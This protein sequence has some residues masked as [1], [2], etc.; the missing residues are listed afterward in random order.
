MRIL[1]AAAE[2]APYIKTGGLGDVIFALPA[3]LSKKSDT[4]V[5]VFLPYYKAIKDNREIETEFITSFYTTLNWRKAHIGI[6]KAK[7]NSQKLK[8]YF[9]DNEYYFGRDNLYGYYDD[10]ERFAYFS[11]ALL[12]A[13]YHIDFVP[14]VIHA[15]DWH[16]ALVPVFLKLWFKQSFENTKC[17]FTVHNIEYQGK[18]PLEFSNEIL[19]FDDAQSSI[20]KYENC[21][22]LM[23]GAI[24]TADK[25]TTVS[26]TYS[27]E[28]KYAYYSYG[29]D[30]VLRENEYK[31]TGIIN[32]IDFNQ[33][34]PKT[35][36]NLHINYSDQEIDK[37]KENK[38]LLQEELNLE[39]NLDI[40]I[41]AMVSRLVPHKGLELVEYIAK[42]LMQENLQFV[43]LGTGDKRYEELF[44]YLENSYKNKVSAN[45]KFDSRLAS[46]IYAGADMLLM[47]S[48]SEP[49]GLSQLIAMR[50]GTV[51]IV[52]ETGGL[53][54]TV[55]ALNPEKLEGRGF[56]FK[57]YNAH[58]ML[59][60]INRCI[61][62]YNDKDNWY[63]LIQ[64]IMQYDSSWK[65]PAS[66]YLNIY[67][68]ISN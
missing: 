11:K 57:L 44:K 24:V 63:K 5:C 12:E 20:L 48:K 42:D 32:G 45:I 28:I 29:L 53:F 60:A 54:D 7:D 52:R 14:D 35:D 49:C 62:F 40:P 64:N 3:E 59:G 66:E 4:E 55:P 9:I 34:N 1:F 31:L 21:I 16:T 47:P 68:G 39:V 50:Y 46:R 8:Y 37:K 41:L 61:D 2:A 13:L 6:F 10:G 43:V 67:K 51:P 33:Y 58:D 17:V 19:G 56:T 38:K 65:V 25:I 30:P 26:K 18:M 36:K 15:N 27:H 22:N 23:K